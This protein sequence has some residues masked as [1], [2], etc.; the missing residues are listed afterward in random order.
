MTRPI[1]MGDEPPPDKPATLA[2]RMR[3]VLRGVPI[4]TALLVGLIVLLAV[5]LI[6]RPLHGEHR[7]WTPAITT[8]VCRI[9]VALIG[10]RFSVRG[11]PMRHIGAVVA[12]HTGWLD[13]YTLNACQKC[14]FV[15]KDE[16]AHWPFAGWL[17]RATGT[18]FIRRDPREAKAQQ[19][20]FEGRIRDGH[21]LLFFPEGTSTDGMQVLPFKTT[22]FAAFYTHG[23]D[24]VMQI[25]PVTVNYTAPEG[26][27]PRFYGWWR[28]MPFASHLIKVLSAPKQGAAEVVFHPPLDVS[29]Y[30]S[31]KDLAAACEAAVRSGL[32]ARSR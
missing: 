11:E 20:I 19:A 22:L 10:L 21:H 8:V 30:P 15:S 6:E 14:Y 23:L 29:D 1:W 32:V 25:Q 27:D 7:P 12:N 5:R 3:L 17:A 26:E 2:D 16:V 4:A 28:D 31:R 18:V 13:I 9:C 24:K